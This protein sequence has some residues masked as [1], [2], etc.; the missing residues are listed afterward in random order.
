[1]SIKFK[2]TANNENG[3]LAKLFRNILFETG[4]INDLRYKIN[5]YINAGGVLTKGSI[6]NKIQH[7]EM[8]WNTFVML[9]F[10]ILKVKKMTLKITLEHDTGIVTEH[11]LVTTAKKKSNKA[12]ENVREDTNKNK[13]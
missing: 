11:T 10:N 2:D 1:M 8:T 9:L 12:N 13:T 6:L 4:A 5:R 7:K 3:L